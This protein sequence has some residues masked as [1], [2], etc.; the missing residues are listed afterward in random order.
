MRTLFLV[1]A[2]LAAAAIPSVPAAAQ[3][4][5]GHNVTIHRGGSLIEDGRRFDRR[6]PR[7]FVSDGRRFDCDFRRNRRGER[8][9][10]RRD[11]V[12][13]DCDVLVGGGFYGGEWA[14]YNN[15]SWE[16]DSYNDWWHERPWRSYP[17]WMQSG[18]CDRL[19][20]GGGGWQCGGRR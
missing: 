1:S 15:R 4:F 9:D 16:H 18:T 8:D 13:R 11:R 14:L 2:A 3:T 7:G 5:S 17:R 12:R 10:R 6:F 19:W 20:W